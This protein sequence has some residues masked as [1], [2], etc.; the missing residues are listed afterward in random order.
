MPDEMGTSEKVM[1]LAMLAT[2]IEKKA[3]MDSQSEPESDTPVP[4]HIH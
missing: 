2:V 3:E 4:H 1:L